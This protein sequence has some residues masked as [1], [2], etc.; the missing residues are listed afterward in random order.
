VSVRED[1]T[2][3]DVKKAIAEDSCWDEAS[4][5]LWRCGVPLRDDLRLA[6]YSIDVPMTLHMAKK[7]VACPTAA[8]VDMFAQLMEAA[9]ASIEMALEATAPQ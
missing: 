5:E 4:M 6:D 2:V 3:F 9:C 8:G 7:E 1:S